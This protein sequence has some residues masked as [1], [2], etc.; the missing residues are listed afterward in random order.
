VTLSVAQLLP[1]VPES[2]FWEITDA[3]NLRCLH[4][5]ADAGRASPDELSTREALDVVEQLARAGCKKAY[6]TG[7]EPLM[8]GDWPLIAQRFRELQVAVFIITNGILVDPSTM[9]RML[10]VGVAGLSVSLDG[11]R[12]VHDAIRVPAHGST[13][14]SYDAALRAI[15]CGVNSPMKTAAVSQIHRKNLHQL[16]QLYELMLALRVAV[17]QVQIC[18]PLGRM[19]A[20]AEEF[21]IDPSDLVTIEQQLASFIEEQ[22]LQI[23]V[24]D[25]IGYYGR[26]EPTLRGAVR[27]TKSFWL[28]CLAG[29]RAVGI[30]SNGDV[31]GCP[32][33]PRSLVVGGLK[34]Q[35]FEEIWADESRFAYNT[36][37]VTEHLS[38]SCRQCS[39][40]R[41][42]RGG[43]RSMALGTSGNMFDNRFCL[44]RITGNVA[45]GATEASPG[46]KAV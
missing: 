15:E 23:A 36:R 27:S 14:S 25:N 13:S 8:R 42:C 43:C 34:K 12:P 16:R 28:G 21:L 1:R 22:R 37:D 17:W 45:G 33:H 2:C 46:T 10:E 20:R 38:E 3:C 32:S 5:E 41:L 18:M 35:P 7:G 30:C 26:N 40:Q 29:C 24:G 11:D 44:Q 6:L 31:K 19:R 9:R 39:Y 4:C